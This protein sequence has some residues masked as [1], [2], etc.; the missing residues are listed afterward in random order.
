MDEEE[1]SQIAEEDWGEQEHQSSL[2]RDTTPVSHSKPRKH[3]VVNISDTQY[4][5]IK[6]VFKKMLGWKVSTDSD[7]T[8]FDL[9]WTDGAVETEKLSHMH[10][11][12]KIN[13]FPGMYSLSKKNYLSRN[14]G[15]MRKTFPAEYSF[16]PLTWVLPAEFA[17]LKTYSIK[18]PKTTYI[19]KPEASSQ[20]RGI[21]LTRS[22]ES[23]GP[24]EHVVVQKYLEKPM[25]I[26]KLKFDM[27]IYV[28]VLG[29]EPLRVFRYEEGLTR[30]ATE[31]YVRPREDNLSNLYLH[32][33]NYSLNK[34]HPDYLFN[35]SLSQSF[36][37]HK[38]SL[39]STFHYFSSLSLDP[40]LLQHQIDDIIIKTLCS[41][42]PSISH[43]YKSCQPEDISNNMCFEILGFDIM[44][45]NKGKP[46][47]LEVNH[48]PAF[49]TDTP[50]DEFVKRNLIK[51]TV[52]L[53]NCKE[54][55]RKM[56]FLK[57]KEELMRRAV[58]GKW[59]KMTKEEREERKGEAQRKRD[60]WEDKHLGGFRKIYP[61]GN[62]NRYA[63]FLT[64]ARTHWEEWTGANISRV[65]KEDNPRKDATPPIPKIP[66]SKRL[67]RSL[68]SNSDDIR[69]KS[70]E[71]TV[72]DRLFK[73]KKDLE[74]KV[75]SVL[76][77]SIYAL[78]PSIKDIFKPDRPISDIPIQGQQCVLP[79][80]KPTRK[81]P[82]L[83]N[84]P[85]LKKY[86]PRYTPF[87]AF[88]LHNQLVKSRLVRQGS[89][90]RRL[91]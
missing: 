6:Y 50:L 61:V 10:S 21:F 70:A 1:G 71:I 7:N 3:L 84:V 8:N 9:W 18:N 25:L 13:H 20:G 82:V 38:R 29:C 42:Q 44:L 53:L 39:T 79:S 76:L 85:R 62:E 89:N 51:D 27:R 43:Y 40:V 78:D 16:Y 59:P 55:M 36:T 80:K 69:P 31:E 57:E 28:L 47:L 34:S 12:Q 90:P 35:T 65:K 15:K 26:E 52:E 41:V 77:P 83:A 22:V 24:L 54:K 11:Y 87:Q 64:A 45:D 56:H 49:S 72:F 5:V 37:G 60:R 75:E 23:L 2:P 63:G 91:M 88:I 30:L 58:K 68:P 32:L 14:L 17:E 67:T 74:K 4:P 66:P 81:S 46:W 33:T 48:S 86:Q 19:V 73:P